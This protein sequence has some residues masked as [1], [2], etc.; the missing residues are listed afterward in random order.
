[1][2]SEDM[3]LVKNRLRE[4]LVMTFLCVACMLPFDSIASTSIKVDSVGVESDGDQSYILHK[5]ESGETLYALSRRYG[6]K[7]GEIVK[8]NAGADKGLK[9]GQ[10]IR[11]P[12]G[13][14]VASKTTSAKTSTI[15]TVKASETLY[16]I[17]RKYGVDVNDIKFW[18]KLSDNNLNVGQ[19][20][21]IRPKPKTDVAKNVIEKTEVEVKEDKPKVEDVVEEVKTETTEA[22][23]IKIETPKE[24]D[25][26]GRVVHT[27]EA[28]QT[29]YSISRTYGVSVGQLRKWN[30]LRKSSTIDIGQKLIVGKSK[31]VAKNDK[32]SEK[33]VKDQTF[34]TPKET[35]AKVEEKTD[36]GTKTVKSSNG[37]TKVVEMGMAEMI[38][39]DTKKY[40]ALHPTAQIGTIVQVRNEM[41]NQSVFVR[42]I[43]KL[44]ATGQTN[45]V[46][47]RISRSAYDRLGAIDRR[48]PVEIS[49]IP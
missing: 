17:S 38:D 12:Y 28:S 4:A 46:L 37:F 14:S 6:S 19:E 3:F 34:D 48:F 2:K 20:L 24:E 1:M 47:I 13:G 10:V 5:V 32:P 40:S 36:S 9:I 49:Y 44:P 27:V 42:V 45:N 15:H 16:S 29:L 43:G 22:P 8:S 31:A 25:F 21:K 23:T 11:I 30:N 35:P 33:T 18:N 41:N 39:T 26:T 7:V